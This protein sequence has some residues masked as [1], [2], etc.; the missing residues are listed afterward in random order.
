MSTTP[1]DARAILHPHAGRDRFDVGWVA[2]PDDL[3]TVVGRHWTVRWSV[4]EPYVQQVLSHPVVQVAVERHD[5]PDGPRYVAEVH[6]V[7]RGTFERQLVGSGRVHGI[8]FRAGT[9]RDLLGADVSTITDRI[10]PAGEV[11]GPD[12]IAVARDAI[13]LDD[14]TAAAQLLDAELRARLPA[15]PDP[16]GVEVAD[17]IERVEEDRSITQAAQL[18]DL[19]GVTPRTLQ[20]TFARHVGAGPKWI[21]R[22][23]RLHE[24]A[25]RLA[26]GDPVDLAELAADLGYSDQPHLTGDFKRAAGRTP[27]DY[28]RAQA[29]TRGP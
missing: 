11:L 25:E 23:Y 19:A 15:T 3:A 27:A 5:D 26:A 20:R 13:D 2:A 28:L 14:D 1:R 21:V 18:A 12:W 17:L 9:F 7:V 24:A 16:V 6:G 10:V 22:T 29:A 8:R 4:R